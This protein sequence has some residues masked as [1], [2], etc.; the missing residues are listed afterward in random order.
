[1]QKR[2]G[3][4]SRSVR[5]CPEKSAPRKPLIVKA[6]NVPVKIYRSDSRGYDTFTVAYYSGSVRKRESF[7]SVVNARERANEIARAII[8][9]RLAVLELTSADREGYLAAVNLLRPLAV[10]L[11]SAI[12]EYVAARSLLSGA[13][14]LTAVQEHVGRR[15][16]VIDKRVR[17]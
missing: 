3:N 4:R 8:N 12:E 11:H 13:P 7:A 6:G 2:A 15:R 9:D 1:M 14:L 10:P 17:E 5:N 16:N